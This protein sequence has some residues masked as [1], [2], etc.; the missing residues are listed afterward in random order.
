MVERGEILWQTPWPLITVS[1]LFF[2]AR[3]AF[4]ILLAV[5]VAQFLAKWIERK[6]PQFVPED[7]A[8]IAGQGGVGSEPG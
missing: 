7:P 8:P 1:S 6:W 4:A 2:L 5:G 3:L